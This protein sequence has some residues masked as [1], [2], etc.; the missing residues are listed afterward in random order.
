MF[1]P[2]PLLFKLIV[3]YQMKFRKYYF[4][5]LLAV[6]LGFTACNDD[7]DVPANGY[8]ETTQEGSSTFILKGYNSPSE[9]YNVFKPEGFGKPFYL[10]DKKFVGS[11]WSFVKTEG[12]QLSSMGEKPADDAWQ[13]TVDVME[14]AAYWAKFK[15]TRNLVYIKMRVAYIWEN[16]VGLEYVNAGEENRD[17]SE[18]L[19]ANQPVGDKTSMT[20]LEIPALNPEHLYADYFVNYENR[21]IQNFALE[22]VADMKHSSW[23]AFSFDTITSQDNVQRENIWEQDDPNID[24]S[25]EVTES[26]HKSDGYDKGHLVASEDRVYSAD[27]NRQTFYYANI[28]P[29]IGSFN[30]KYWAALEKRVQ[31]W[32]R[33]TQQNVYDKVYLTKGGTLNK[34]LTNFTGTVMANDKQYPTTDEFGKTKHGLAVPAYY[35]MAILSEKDGNYHAV[36]FYVPH[37]ETLPQNPTAG[38]FQVYAVTIDKLEEETGID[39]FCNLPDV[40]E[41]EVEASLNFSDWNWN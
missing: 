14:G 26:M 34:L 33:S 4:M 29:Q 38:D 25:I 13:S 8:I 32:G 35:F 40:I 22:Y 6:S 23:V 17:L 5:F 15:G 31:T 2:A 24:N 18:N 21:N 30:G 10:K 11:A 20:A 9:G 36:G 27:A 41:D 37:T 12:N 28:S 16:N 7:S 1:F 39:F 19:N 3:S